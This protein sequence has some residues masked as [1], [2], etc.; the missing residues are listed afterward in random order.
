[1]ECLLAA[2]VVALFCA[3]HARG[4]RVECNQW[5]RIVKEQKDVD[6]EARLAIF[7]AYRRLQGWG[8]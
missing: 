7:E 1:M 8:E 6:P 5:I 3:G 2:T 4:R